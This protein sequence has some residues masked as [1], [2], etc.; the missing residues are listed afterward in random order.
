[1]LRSLS[2]MVTTVLLLLLSIVN[3]KYARVWKVLDRVPGPGNNNTIAVT[4]TTT[5]ITTATKNW[6][7]NSKFLKVRTKQMSMMLEDVDRTKKIPETVH[8]HWTLTLILRIN[9]LLINLS[10][11]KKFFFGCC[12]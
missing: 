5:S 6:L 4:S 3:I 8:S 11:Q 9:F 10:S 12:F 2:L 1:M 7:C